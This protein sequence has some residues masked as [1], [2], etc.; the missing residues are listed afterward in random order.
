MKTFVVLLI[1]FFTLTS[2]GIIKNLTGSKEE[3]KA[4][5]VKDK[6]EEVKKDTK[7]EENTDEKTESN[8]KVSS[9]RTDEI[10]MKDFNKSDLPS[11]IKYQGGIITGKRWT[12]KNGENIII[13][14]LTKEHNTKKTSYSDEYMRSKELCGYQY[15]KK[16]EGWS[17]LWKINDFVSD[18]E[19]DITLDFIGGS[20][21]I[22]DLNKNGI[23][24]STFLY[25]LSCRSDVSPSSMKLIMH[26]GES[27]Y[28]IRGTMKIYEANRWYGGEYKVDKSFDE[29][30][31]G[32]LDYAKE[33]WKKNNVEK[34]N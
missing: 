11:D 24:E 21:S 13:L 34:F 26:E 20:L 32:F 17:Q 33:Q 18:C 3:K 8:E 15:V 25:R 22:T 12:D 9:G 31:S 5:D 6:K 29:A 16:S 30:P 10:I 27:K 19:F 28:A 7:T 4:E 23:G 14:S 2:C 1:A